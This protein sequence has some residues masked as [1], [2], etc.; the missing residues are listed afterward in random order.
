ME[1]KAAL[2]AIAGPDEIWKYFTLELNKE[3]QLQ[4]WMEA[5]MQERA[6]GK[7]MPFVIIS[8]D[9]NKICGCTSLGNISFYDKRIEIGWT[10][11][12]TASMGS[13][14]NHHAKVCFIKLCT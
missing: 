14:T 12:G 8:K 1:D 11:L 10:W 5:A 13:G 7:R 6:E 3:D 2:A 9:D 4:Q